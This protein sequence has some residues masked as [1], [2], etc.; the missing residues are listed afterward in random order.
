MKIQGDAPTSARTGVPTYTVSEEDRHVG[1]TISEAVLDEMKEWD[2]LTRQEQTARVA[3]L[4]SKGMPP[5]IMTVLTQEELDRH[6]QEHAAFAATLTDPLDLAAVR[7]GD[8]EWAGPHAI[9]ARNAL[10]RF[11]NQ[12]SVPRGGATTASGTGQ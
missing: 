7:Y 2:A 1:W 3:A 6:H 11:L 5:P 12:G 8:T 4:Q 10:R 9:V